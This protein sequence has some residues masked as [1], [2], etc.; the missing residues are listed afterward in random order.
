MDS[1][2]AQPDA[3]L[4]KSCN[5]ACAPGFLCWSES[6]E[7]PGICVPPCGRD[8]DCPDSYRCT[9]SLGVCTP[10]PESTDDDDDGTR[11]AAGCSCRTAPRAPG[12]AWAALSTLLG[13][14]TLGARRRRAAKPA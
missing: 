7:P 4:G 3:G 14:V 6:S 1:G 2:T 8:A 9:R 12:A 5:N 10:A 13:I 11:T